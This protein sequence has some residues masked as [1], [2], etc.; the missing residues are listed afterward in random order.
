MPGVKGKGEA[1]LF[2]LLNEA[3][4]ELTEIAEDEKEDQA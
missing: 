1:V 4:H 3:I 2:V